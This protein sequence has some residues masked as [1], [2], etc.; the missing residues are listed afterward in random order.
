MPDV[1][2]PRQPDFLVIENHHFASGSAPRPRQLLVEVRRDP[3]VTVSVK[4]WL[5]FRQPL[6]IRHGRSR[7]RLQLPPIVIRRGALP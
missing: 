5:W 3:A 1:Q 7:A 2:Q 6:G 4:H